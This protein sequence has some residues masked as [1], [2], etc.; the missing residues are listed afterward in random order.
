MFW[1]DF[2]SQKGA[3]YD[4]NSLSAEGIEKIIDREDFTALPDPSSTLIWI[5]YKA[6]MWSDLQDPWLRSNVNPLR[7]LDCE[8]VSDLKQN[9]DTATR[10]SQ[11][12][13][14]EKRLMFQ[15]FDDN[16]ELL[17]PQRKK[18]HSLTREL[19]GFA[20]QTKNWLDDDVSQ[21][22]TQAAGPLTLRDESCSG[23]QTRRVRS[24]VVGPSPLLGPRSTD[25][26]VRTRSPAIGGSRQNTVI[27][28]GRPVSR[29]AAHL[30]ASL[31][32]NESA[33]SSLTPSGR[34]RFTPSYTKRRT[35]H[36]VGVDPIEE[37]VSRRKISGN[38]STA[39]GIGLASSP[40]E[41]NDPSSMQQGK[42]HIRSKSPKLSALI[43]LVKP[44]NN[45]MNSTFQDQEVCNLISG[46]RAR[47]QPSVRGAEGATAAVKDSEPKPK[48]RFLTHVAVAVGKLS[49]S[50][51]VSMRASSPVPEI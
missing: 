27:P 46:G 22:T 35:R 48:F 1:V 14:A 36:E 31:Q 40:K 34:T 47:Q 24:P 8:S 15:Q 42:Q 29:D 4:I 30:M 17:V 11:N 20:A 23:D 26:R 19:E 51:N 25:F 18:L 38:S 41:R 32:D 28:S 44:Q 6:S 16:Q 33:R 12:S 37:L 3:Q 50:V 9:Q 21:S 43:S 45:Y 2:R 10:T 5:F 7:I 39:S 49:Q 13:V